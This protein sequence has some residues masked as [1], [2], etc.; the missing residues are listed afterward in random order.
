MLQLYVPPAGD[1]PAAWVNTADRYV[2][3][4]P[5]RDDKEIDPVAAYCVR[6][7]R[8]RMRKGNPNTGSRS[9]SS[10]VAFSERHSWCTSTAPAHQSATELTGVQDAAKTLCPGLSTVSRTEI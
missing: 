10:G 7:M 4:K 6:H 1:Q 5:R 8:D 3:L 2:E 9:V